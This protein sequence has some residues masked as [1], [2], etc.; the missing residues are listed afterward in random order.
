MWITAWIDVGVLRSGDCNKRVDCLVAAG[1]SMCACVSV[2]RGRRDTRQ[3][4]ITMVVIALQ[5]HY[6]LACR[7]GVLSYV[8]FRVTGA[9]NRHERWQE[10]E[11]QRREWQ[12]FE[13][14]PQPRCARREYR[15][16][17]TWNPRLKRACRRSSQM[18]SDATARLHSNSTNC[19]WRQKKRAGTTLQ[20]ACD[21]EF[22]R[23]ADLG[24]SIV[25]PS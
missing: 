4:N 8:T 16:R 3:L 12:W 15:R 23:F 2:N 25:K 9:A 19:A 18:R 6:P 1:H 11:R 21:D 20:Q 14:T 13:R 7:V 22:M 17:A 5:L 10:P 24:L